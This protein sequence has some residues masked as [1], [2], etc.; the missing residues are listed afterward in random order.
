MLRIATFNLENLFTRP[1]AMN[2]ATDAA[3]RQ[4]IEDHSELNGIIAHDVYS[5]EDTERLVEL[6]N[7]YKFHA[8]NPPE[9]ALVK[10][11]K[12]RGRLF[13]KPKNEPLKVV[14]NGREDWT[15][16]FELR[17]DDVAWQAPY[18]TARVI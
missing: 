16:W 10:M 5:P 1:S 3:G 11:Q 9:N 8:L 2:Q 18:H 13:R 6:S 4:A 12:I 14:A 17:R 7:C 15:G